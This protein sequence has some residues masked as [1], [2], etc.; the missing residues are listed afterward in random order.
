MIHQYLDWW[1]F[2][3]KLIPLNIVIV[4]EIVPLEISKTDQIII[5]ITILG[6]STN[7]WNIKSAV[8][9]KH[10]TIIACDVIFRYLK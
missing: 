5:F 3:V 6:E 7:L 8:G 1:I 2:E 9:Y 10:P 4:Y